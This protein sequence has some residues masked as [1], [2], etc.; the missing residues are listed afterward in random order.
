MKPKYFTQIFFSFLILA[1]GAWAFYEYKKSQKEQEKE[2]Q[3]TTF[4][5]K[6]LKELK[7][8]RIKKKDTELEVTQENEDWVLKQ[9]LKD[10]ASFKEISRWFDEIGNQKV[11]KI[12]SDE[13]IKWENYYLDPAPQVE[14]EFS[15]GETISF[16]VSRKSFFNGKYFIRKG[17][18]LY[19]GESYFAS[20]VN[21]KSFDDFR[22]KKLFSFK[23]HVTKI[24]F[25]GKEKFTVQWTDSKWS[26][27]KAKPFPLDEN[28]LNDFWSDVKTM[29]AKTIKESVTPSL[30]RKY[31]LHKA[32][33]KI[34][35]YDSSNKEYSLSL[36]PVKQDTT[37]VV[38]SGRDYIFEIS[39]DN[40]EKT[41][42]L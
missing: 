37:F 22:S 41:Y 30:L 40:A 32:Q 11:Q 16:S 26:L 29:E 25:Q 1:F 2:A 33:L 23:D 5:T 20:E 6:E 4:L 38:V 19:V 35:F 21:N 24:Q 14:M 10:K 17:E 34:L 3:E 13:D 27:D 18:E 42:A 36:S 28:R 31:N 7:A 15:S 9:P 8:F 12:E 39:K